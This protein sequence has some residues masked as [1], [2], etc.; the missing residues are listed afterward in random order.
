MCVF[1]GQGGGMVGGVKRLYKSRYFSVSS[2]DLEYFLLHESSESMLNKFLKTQL[3]TQ[4]PKDWV[5]QVLKDLQEL[6]ID[7]N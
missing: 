2:F 5:T 3:K 7:M 6:K 4:K 1:E